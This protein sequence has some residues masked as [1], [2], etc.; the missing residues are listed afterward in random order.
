MNA[1]IEPVDLARDL[2]AIAEIARH[3]FSHPWSREMFAHEFSL[4]PLTRSYVLR[5]GQHP[6]A[7]FCT[8]WLVVDELHVN[9]LAVRP[10]LRRQ[11]LARVLMEHVL[12]E[13]VR[14]G[15]RRVLLEVRRS[16]AAA[17]GLYEG[18]GF[19]VEAVRTGYY[20]HPDEDA[21]VLGRRLDIPAEK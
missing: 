3:S 2:D 17:I 18:L 15:A 13:A 7:A 6:V 5:T 1:I 9:T 8:C 12:Q 14:Q 21:F 20:A 4:Q 11:G 10:E 16:N 19:A